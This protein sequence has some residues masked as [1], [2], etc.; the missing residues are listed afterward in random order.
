M[1]GRDE[2]P[3]WDLHAGL[4]DRRLF[5]RSD[6]SYAPVAIHHYIASL[7]SLASLSGNI[8]SEA[9][10]PAYQFVVLNQVALRRIALQANPSGELDPSVRLFAKAGL[11][12]A[13]GASFE[14]IV[15]SEWGSRFLPDHL[16]M[17][18]WL[19]AAG[20]SEAAS[21][22]RHVQDAYSEGPGGFDFSR[23]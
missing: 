4:S 11:D 13:S 2:P 15:P 10:P 12:V 7:D 16:C 5:D 18:G 19:Q 3:L 21:R 1:V 8:L 17:R 22:R 23:S 9:E 20:Q 14:L 6:F